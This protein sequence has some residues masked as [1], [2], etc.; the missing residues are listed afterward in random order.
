MARSSGS[1]KVLD[2]GVGT[3]LIINGQQLPEHIW[4]AHTNL[5]NPDLLLKIHKSFIRAGA[6]YITTNTFRTTQRAYAKIGL[7]DADAK[8]AADKSLT[9]AVGLSRHL[10]TAIGLTYILA[11]MTP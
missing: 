9:A 1:I 2:G 10:K 6:Q 7:S 11:R 8:I 3:E 4:S 5:N